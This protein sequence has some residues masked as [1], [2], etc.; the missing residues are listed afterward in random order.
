MAIPT[1]KLSDPGIFS[2]EIFVGFRSKDGI[3]QSTQSLRTLDIPRMV[4]SKNSRPWDAGVCLNFAE[5]FLHHLRQTMEQTSSAP[6]TVWRLTFIPR[7]GI[8]LEIVEDQDMLD[9]IRNGEDRVGFLPSEFFRARNTA[10]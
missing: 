10:R 8:S 4:R 3:L 5:A 1:R 9:E 7:R 2:K 6:E